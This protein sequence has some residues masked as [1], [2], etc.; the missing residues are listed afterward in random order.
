M[1]RVVRALYVALLVIVSARIT[2][3]GWS[4]YPALA[5]G[6]RIL[7][8]RL[9]FIHH[10]PGRGDIVLVRGVGNVD[11]PIIKRIVGVPKDHVYIGQGLV[12]VNGSPVHDSSSGTGA[13]GRENLW[14]L[15]ENEY[16]L[17]GDASD[18]STDSR[19]FGP[20]PARTI[21]AKAW[22]VWWPY[23]RRR[24]VSGV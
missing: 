24:I 12:L 19:S 6:E 15:S 1:R 3:V 9:A 2:V 7:L 17:L 8:D 10:R 5:P 14:T 11:G 22:L 13:H 4:M 16:F 21:R 18:F 23:H 20:I